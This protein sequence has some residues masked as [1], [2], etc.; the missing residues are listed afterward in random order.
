MGDLL[1]SGDYEI[2]I[3]RRLTDALNGE[4]NRFIVLK[5]AIIAPINRPQQAERIAELFVEHNQIVLAVPLKEPDP[6]KEFLKEQQPA[7]RQSGQAMFFTSHFALRG[8]FYKR[9]DLSEQETLNQ[10]TDDFI[11]LTGVRFS[12]INGGQAQSRNFVCLARQQILAVYF[13]SP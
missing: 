10:M 8:N 1:I 7:P 11:P 4:Q 9:V 2:T 3:Y 13:T 12:P 5:N 6:P